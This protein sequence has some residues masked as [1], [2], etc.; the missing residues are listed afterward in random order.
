MKRI[1][2]VYLPQWPIERLLRDQKRYSKIRDCDQGEKFAA[3]SFEFNKPFGLVET[4]HRGIR[5]SAVNKTAN[6][7]GVRAGDA[8]ADAR[9]I[10]P[11]LSVSEALPLADKHGLRK[12]AQW[13]GRY[14][15]LRNAY[16]LK[17]GHSPAHS[18]KSYGLWIDISGVS[19]LYGGETKL[20]AD[21]EQQ[22]AR[23]GVTAFAA[24]ADTFGAAHALAWHSGSEK[25]RIRQAS[26]GDTLAAIADLPVVSLRLDQ[27]LV[28]LLNRLGFKQIGALAK[29]PR[30]ALEQRFFLQKDSQR[31]LLR[32]DQALGQR[33]EPRRPLR[34]PPI[35]SVQQLYVD[36]L[37]TDE[38]FQNEVGSLVVKFCVKLA[39]AGLGARAVRLVFFRCDGTFGEIFVLFSCAVSKSDHI[40]GLL[41]EKLGNIDL[42]FG[43]DMMALEAVNVEKENSSQV[44]LTG[45]NQAAIAD[46]TSQLVD[47]LVNKLGKGCVTQLSS[48]DSHWPERREKRVNALSQVSLISGHD[49][50]ALKNVIEPQRP[51]LLFSPPERITVTAEIPEGAPVQFA[52]RRVSYRIHR[53]EGP[54]R[55]EPE[56]WMAIEK[57][58][59][60]LTRDYYT[61][62]DEFG[63]RFWIFRSGRY[64]SD[65]N[66]LPEWF[67]HGVF[68]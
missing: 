19:H 28:E 41:R 38:I 47:R 3:H 44:S 22:L 67:L 25:Q 68:A 12:L 4:S 18:L 11:S 6:D 60:F 33:P 1:V 51:A 61:L 48:K 37:I 59:E 9:A 15:I 35:L 5:L 46:L 14:G 32:L 30:I 17:T 16:G 31:V 52:W 57:S 58:H 65:C 43:V 53:S 55:I 40:L 64:N 39:N 45:T 54:E 24:A 10:L 2:S 13:C 27:T 23:F 63:T 20:L 36:P 26:P 50:R 8:L 34:E 56:W 29:L 62:E 21:I 42:G 7:Q 66:R 49:L